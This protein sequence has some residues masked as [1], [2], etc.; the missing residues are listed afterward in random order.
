MALTR[1]LAGITLAAGIFALAPL[2]TATAA[3]ATEAAT[4]SAA[5]QAAFKPFGPYFAAG[6]KAKVSGSLTA[7]AKDDPS[8][9][10]PWVKV[11]GSVVDRTRSSSACG[12]ALFRVSWFDSSNTPHLAYR[13]YRTCSYNVKKTFAFTMKNVGEVEL[14]VCSEGKAAKPSINCQYAGT[15]KTLYA[16]YK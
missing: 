8:A 11:S 15:W 16:Y 2:A 14:K 1:S 13:N 4:Q 5:A 9:P 6:S 10:A 7:A 3:S 12:W